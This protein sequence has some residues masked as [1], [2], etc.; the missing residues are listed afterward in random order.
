MSSHW[1][2]N[3]LRCKVEF[4]SPLKF[5]P[6][7][8]RLSN[9]NF[10]RGKLVTKFT[11]GRSGIS[12]KCCWQLICGR[13]VQVL[14]SQKLFPPGCSSLPECANKFLC[15][16]YFFWWL[17]WRCVSRQWFRIAG[18]K[19]NRMMPLFR[20]LFHST[21]SYLPDEVKML[22]NSV[23]ANFLPACITSNDT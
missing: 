19:K 1:Q 22:K 6:S 12:C 14:Q 21:M 3:L 10:R 9:M 20:M 17:S 2:G 7:V 5:L 11:V 13:E 23:S 8:C 18:G 16:A 15:D 4:A